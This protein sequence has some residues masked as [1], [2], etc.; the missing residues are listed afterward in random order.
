MNIIS[1]SVPHRYHVGARRAW[2]YRAVKGAL[3]PPLL[4]S[5]SPGV[6]PAR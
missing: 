5:A 2:W 1:L 6:Y 3:P 4:W